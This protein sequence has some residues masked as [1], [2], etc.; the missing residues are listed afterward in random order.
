MLKGIGPNFFGADVFQNSFSLFGIVP[1]ISLLGDEFF[2]IYF[3]ALTIVVKDT[4]S[5]R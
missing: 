2:I 5:R 1:E 3:N 4:S